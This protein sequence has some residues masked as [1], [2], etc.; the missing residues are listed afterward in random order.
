M[1]SSRPKRSRYGDPANIRQD[2]WTVRQRWITPT[3]L[4]VPTPSLFAVRSGGLCIEPGA[5][6]RAALL[7]VMPLDSACHY[8]TGLRG[9]P[10]TRDRRRLP[11]TCGC[12]GPKAASTAAA[13][14]RTSGNPCS[15]CRSKGLE[16]VLRYGGMLSSFQ[17]CQTGAMDWKGTKPVSRV[18]RQARCCRRRRG[19]RQRTTNRQVAFSGLA[20]LSPVLNR[21]LR[22]TT[23]AVALGSLEETT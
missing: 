11:L 13:A 19:A 8:A 16:P 6:A 20:D 17:R 1:T 3:A 15:G 4:R 5:L 12:R 21:G 18:L 9:L 7:W 22:R 2:R 10:I 23:Q 14:T